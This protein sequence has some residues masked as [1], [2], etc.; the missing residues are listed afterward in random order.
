MPP[1]LPLTSLLYNPASH[2]PLQLIAPR[3]PPPRLYPPPSQSTSPLSLFCRERPSPAQSHLVT[4]DKRQHV[5]SSPWPLAQCTTT[6][7]S[8]ARLSRLI[9]TC[10]PLRTYP[11]WSDQSSR[12]STHSVRVRMPLRGKRPAA[13]SDG[14][15]SRKHGA[16]A[17]TNRQAKGRGGADP[18]EVPRQDPCELHC[19]PHVASSR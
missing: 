10:R 12:T 6:T 18:T 11:R 15:H 3:Q 7:I 9:L 4:V 8:S 14:D 13:L 2:S 1:V 5:P 16:G 19:L 17:D